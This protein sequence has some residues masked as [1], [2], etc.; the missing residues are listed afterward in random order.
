V[1]LEKQDFVESLPSFFIEHIVL[2]EY[3]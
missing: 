1:I 3:N 2:E